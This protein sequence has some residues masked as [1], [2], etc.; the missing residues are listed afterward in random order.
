[1][2]DE[3]LMINDVLCF[4]STSRDTLTSDEAIIS[5]T[6][7]Y[8]SDDIL[9]A[10]KIIFSLCKEKLT[11]RRSCPEHPNP[12]VADIQDI[13]N[14]LHKHDK[15]KKVFPKFVAESHNSLPPSAGFLAFARAFNRIRDELSEVKEEL[16]QVKEAKNKENRILEESTDLKQDIAD[17]KSMLLLKS[18]VAT[19]S[20][21][22]TPVY[23]QATQQPTQAVSNA[24]IMSYSDA[25]K[26]T[27]APFIGERP[28]KTFSNNFK[29]NQMFAGS[30]NFTNNIQRTYGPRKQNN[31]IGTYRNSDDSAFGFSSAPRK[32]DIYVGKCDLSTTA[33]KILNFCKNKIN[34]DAIECTELMTKNEWYKCFKVTAD[35][36]VRDQLLTPDFWPCGVIVRKFIAPRKRHFSNNGR[37]D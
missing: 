24:P 17:I 3:N 25:F 20:D 15:G 14:L 37:F 18:V 12:T 19:P 21:M 16:K 2:P 22:T 30:R 28:R 4:L 33:A 9:S 1:M 34:S 11:V 35:F 29:D 23:T 5:A 13:I 8:N 7:F 10:K 31:I 36:N 32:L 27:T 6:A 26:S